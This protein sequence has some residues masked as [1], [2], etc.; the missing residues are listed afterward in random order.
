MYLLKSKQKKRTYL[1]SIEPSIHRTSR[2]E[3]SLNEK[4][5]KFLD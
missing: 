4:M 1:G 5:S 3:G 2:L